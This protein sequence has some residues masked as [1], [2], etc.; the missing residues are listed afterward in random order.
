MWRVHYLVRLLLVFVSWLV[1][2]QLGLNLH[3]ADIT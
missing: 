2:D 1:Y 3:W